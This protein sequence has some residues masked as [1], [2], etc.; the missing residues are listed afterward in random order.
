MT[1]LDWVRVPAVQLAA[2]S[3]T[4]RATKQC[5]KCHVFCRV[6]DLESAKDLRPEASVCDARELARSHVFAKPNCDSSYRHL[7]ALVLRHLRLQTALPLTIRSG[8]VWQ[9]LLRMRSERVC[10]NEISELEANLCSFRELCTQSFARRALHK[11]LHSTKVQT[12]PSLM[13]I[14]TKSRPL[15]T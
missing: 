12:M 10:R 6:T 14:G 5:E 3:C 1:G 9:S 13:T 15:C 2:E 11:A 7:S 8:R 4:A